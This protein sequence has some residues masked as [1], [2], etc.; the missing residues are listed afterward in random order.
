MVLLTAVACLCGVGLIATLVRLACRHRP[1][2]WITSDTAILC[3]VTPFMII[4]VTFGGVAVGYR[5]ANGG[6]GAVP[7]EG[8][9]ASVVLVGATIF[10]HRVVSRRLRR[11]AALAAHP[12]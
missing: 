11:S 2:L 8:W 10:V 4:L 3:A 6:L 12:A 9:I 5:L 1:D 7:A